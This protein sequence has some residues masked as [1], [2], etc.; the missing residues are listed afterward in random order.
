VIANKRALVAA[1]EP[2]LEAALQHA[3]Q[4]QPA[5]FTSEE[6]RR[7]VQRARR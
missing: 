2:G 1:S 4:V 5:R 7:A 6:F 3:A